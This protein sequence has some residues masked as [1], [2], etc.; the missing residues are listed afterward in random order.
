[1]AHT[2]LAV[3]DATL[4]RQLRSFL[5]GPWWLPKIV[6]LAFLLSLTMAFPPVSALALQD[7]Y[8][9]HGWKVRLSKYEQPLLDMAKVFPP[10]SHHAKLTFR[11]TMP[12]L[13]H[14]L[15]FRQW[16][17]LA[18]Q[19]LGGL[20]L[21]GAFGALAYRYTQDRV[22]AAYLMLAL[23]V[24]FPGSAA[25][26]ELYPRFD[27]ISFFLLVLAQALTRPWAVGSVVF[28]ASWNDERGLIASSLVLLYHVFRQEGQNSWLRRFLSPVC[29][30]IYA[31][32]LLY[33]AIRLPLAARYGLHTAGVGAEF[34]KIDLDVLVLGVWSALKFGLLYVLLAWFVAG[35]QR[36]WFALACYVGACL[37]VTTVGILVYDITRSMAY[38]LPAVPAAWA[39]LR[40]SGEPEAADPARSGHERRLALAVFLGCLILPTFE[41]YGHTVVAAQPLYVYLCGLF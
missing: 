32:W 21:L 28:L 39:L 26:T 36:Q 24:C 11:L 30:A 41:L 27:A 22:A 19:F 12:V 9:V 3:L 34:L 14:F 31:A 17:S 35:R 25:F 18:I 16:G 15:G 6:L 20:V 2:T 33:F 40:A 5:T 10:S 37:I 1:M 38:L 29:L 7:G 8:Y 23:A 13:G 4:E